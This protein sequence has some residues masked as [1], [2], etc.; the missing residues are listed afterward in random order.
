M[1]DFL[2]GIRWLTDSAHWW[3]IGGIANRLREHVWY[4]L[5]A[6]L[7]AMAFALPIGMIIGHTGRGR[8]VAAST[9][10][11][12]RAIP[13]F[14]VVALLFIWKP[15]S[16]WPVLVSLAVLAIPPIMLNTAAGIDSVDPQARDA[17]R[18]MGL[19]GWQVLTRVELPCAVPLIL[20]GVRSAANQVI[21][22]AT[23][24]GFKGLGGLGRFIFTGYGTQHYD[25]VYGASVAVVIVVLVVELAFALLQSRLVSPGLQPASTRLITRGGTHRP[26]TGRPVIEQRSFE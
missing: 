11:V 25:V 7:L 12:L 19:T 22:T 4:S 2:D 21:A 3:G 10:T 17:A 8:F 6:T 1:N 20:A 26:S 15:L 24:A 18:G 9:G 13:T 23:V 5:L 16:L 14:G